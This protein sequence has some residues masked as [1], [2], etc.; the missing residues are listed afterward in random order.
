MISYYRQC[1]VY[2]SVLSG[3]RTL[4]LLCYASFAMLMIAICIGLQGVFFHCLLG[5][6]GIFPQRRQRHATVLRGTVRETPSSVFKRLPE[7]VA[8]ALGKFDALHAGHAALVARVRTMGHEPWLLSFSGMAEVLGWAPRLPITALEHRSDV[9]K[10]WGGVHECILPFEEVRWLSPSAFVDVLADTLTVRGVVCGANFR[11]GYRASGDASDLDV[12]ATARGLNVTVVDLVD[13]GL[14]GLTVSSTRVREAL[15][16]GDLKNAEALLGRP[17]RVFWKIRVDDPRSSLHAVGLHAPSNQPPGTGSYRVSAEWM[18]SGIKS[19]VA[20][21]LECDDGSALLQFEPP[22]EL[23][24]M[25][26]QQG[27]V[28]VVV[29]FDSGLVAGIA[30]LEL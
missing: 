16:D 26:S 3:R 1:K 27:V 15:A 20:A 29:I 5:A 11:F 13:S 2:R 21:T 30:A 23:T 7:N 4:I 22:S 24:E 12:L 28:S 6:F 14:H 25:L 17:H 19:V 8:V 10:S 18:A 9:L